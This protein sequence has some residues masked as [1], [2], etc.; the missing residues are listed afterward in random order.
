MS[1]LILAIEPQHLTC[2]TYSDS[3]ELAPVR[4]YARSDAQTLAQTLA[5]VRDGLSDAFQTVVVQIA[6]TRFLLLPNAF[7]RD[8]L[9][10]RLLQTVADTYIGEQT[11]ADELPLMDA[12][13]I[14][15]L[16]EETMQSITAVFPVAQFRHIGTALL[17]G[18]GKISAQ[19]QGKKVI[20]F[21]KNQTLYVAYFNAN[22]P[23][24][25]LFNSFECGATADFLYYI[26]AIYQQF[27][28]SQQSVPL[29]ATGELTVQSD[30]HQLLLRYIAHVRWWSEEAENTVPNHHFDLYQSP[31]AHHIY[32]VVENDP[33]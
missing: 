23:T 9:K 7:F 32:S 8:D 25:T 21:I 12:K 30:L 24:P 26:L 20:V 28:L 6:D 29:Y 13:N 4:V 14:Y 10:E 18:F 16:S 33:N 27:E 17:Y 5:E 15:P 2:R 19:K 22:T 11:A 31:H 3:G 1:S